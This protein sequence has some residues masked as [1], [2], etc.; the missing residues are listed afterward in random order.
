MKRSDHAASYSVSEVAAGSRGPP[1]F[2]AENIPF[3]L[4]KSAQPELH[5]SSITSSKN[6][7]S[8]IFA[9]AFI[10]S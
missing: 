9:S 7:L 4:S 1:L 2:P 3:N 6:L 8:A 10:M 5:K